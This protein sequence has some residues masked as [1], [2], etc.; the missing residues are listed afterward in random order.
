MQPDIKIGDSA[1]NIGYLKYIGDPRKWLKI[2]MQPFDT[3]LGVGNCCPW[4]ETVH[5]FSVQHADVKELANTPMHRNKIFNSDTGFDMDRQRE[6]FLSVNGNKEKITT[7]VK[8][9]VENNIQKGNE[10]SLKRIADAEREILDLKKKIEEH[11]AFCNECGDYL[12][13]RCDNNE[14]LSP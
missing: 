3:I 9:A 4:N 13:T 10:Y 5:C 8:K 2:N 1:I 7:L 11:T 14:S 6:Q 12:I